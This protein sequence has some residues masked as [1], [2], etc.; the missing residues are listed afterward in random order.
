MGGALPPVYLDTSEEGSAA[1][2]VR[3]FLAQPTPSHLALRQGHEDPFPNATYYALVIAATF[4]EEFV[5]SVLVNPPL[6][7]ARRG[8][9]VGSLVLH[10]W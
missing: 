1:T 4:H 5:P 6:L 3:L 9:W 8:P 10:G 2:A 7:A